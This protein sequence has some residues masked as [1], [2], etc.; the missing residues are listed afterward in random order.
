M[1]VNMRTAIEKIPQ[2]IRKKIIGFE[3]ESDDETLEDL[4]GMISEAE[5]CKSLE[6]FKLEY[7]YD[8]HEMT[9][10]DNFDVDK[11]AEIISCYLELVDNN[12]AQ[13]DHETEI[14]HRAILYDVYTFEHRGADDGTY[15]YAGSF[16]LKILDVIKAGIL[17]A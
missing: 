5:A 10:P 4:E 12:P 9:V 13:W 1:K 7:D 15:D 17:S 3:Y 8:T 11:A 16:V 14:Q 2:D 6:F